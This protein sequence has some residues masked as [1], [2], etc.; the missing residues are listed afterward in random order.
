MRSPPLIHVVDDDEPVR[1]ALLRLLSASGFEA[2]GYGSAAAFLMTSPPDRPGCVL[3]D[4]RMPGPSGLDLQATL[5][6]R[7]MTLPVIF[8]TGHADVASSVRAMKT[9]AVDFLTKPIDS[10]TLFEAIRRALTLD[11]SE[12]ASRVEATRMRAHFASLTPREREVFEL[13]VAGRLNKQIAG[14]L[15]IAERTVKADRAQVLAK[16]GVSS[17]AALGAFAE[18]LRQLAS[19]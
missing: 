3:L 19:G 10:E 18:R 1:T 14:Q 5:R 8:L 15:G 6:E 16:L 9:G 12:R 13:V 17:A 4:L 7:S 11:A 2:Q